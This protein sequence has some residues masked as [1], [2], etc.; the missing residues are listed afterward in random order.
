MLTSVPCRGAMVWAGRGLSGLG[1][2]GG[3]GRG[4]LGGDSRRGSAPGVSKLEDIGDTVPRG[5]GCAGDIGDGGGGG[6]KCGG[7]S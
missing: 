1:P 3:P 7:D 6:L 2:I 4:Q 5:E